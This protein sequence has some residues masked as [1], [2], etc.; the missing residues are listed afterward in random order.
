MNENARFV[1]YSDDLKKF[2]IHTPPWDADVCR[3]IP[4]RRFHAQTKRWR[5]PAIRRNLE[6]FKTALQ[7][8]SWTDRAR[9]R[10]AEGE[11]SG[12]AKHIPFPTDHVF[13]T[14]ARWYQKEA[15]DKFF[16]LKAF[17]LF[18]EMRTGKTK[19]VIDLANAW[20]QV[21]RIDRVLAYSPPSVLLAWEENL[22]AH[23]A[24]GYDL[25]FYDT[26][27]KEKAKRWIFAEGW[28]KTGKCPWMI[29]PIT[30]MA[31]SPE[32]VK[33]LTGFVKRGK[34]L[35]VVD[36]SIKIK[37][38]NANTT[39][40]VI[41][42]GQLPQVVVK[43]IMNGTPISVGVE[44]LFS[45]FEY[46]DPDI[47]GIGDY[48]SFRNR[49][50]IMGGYERKQIVGYQYTDEL[51]DLMKP[52][53]YEIDKKTALPD[54]PPK[55]YMT[56]YY[57]PSKDQLALMKQ[58]KADR[59]AV[60][61]EGKVSLKNV[62]GVAIKSQQILGGFV[63][64][65]P[66]LDALGK[67]IPGT[68]KVQPV[69]ATNPKVDALMEALTQV[70]G[71]VVIWIRYAEEARVITGKLV[72]AFGGDQVV[73]MNSG[74][75]EQALAHRKA[76]IHTFRNHAR[77]MVGNPAVGGMGLDLS[78][79]DTEIF[80]TSPVSYID[81]WQAEDRAH[82]GAGHNVLILDLIGKGTIEED[83]IE[84]RKMKLDLS[85]YIKLKMRG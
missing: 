57:T 60:F 29:V 72:A 2:I 1:D 17:A 77:F 5:A 28:K 84:A 71:K 15:L 24:A 55:T 16:G 68:G 25:F 62:L 61:E 73:F 41:E 39:G 44:D 7:T 65:N 33:V 3:N 35:S 52:F 56:R 14:V 51:F 83:M 80:Y 4:N 70:T 20:F 42:I 40:N 26:S 64:L 49:Y 12:V 82:M 59:E 45:Q 38:P 67:P 34:A 75:D 66:T 69:G 37:T 48:W 6:Y 36:E 23:D 9:E 78:A 18:A 74:T 79:A 53:T 76:A 19:I 43:G 58:L 47:I 8:A 46:L 22:E 32:T 11:G 81:R 85:E 63:Y 13:K 31:Q 30:A 10:L 21:G 50:C 27:N 54:L